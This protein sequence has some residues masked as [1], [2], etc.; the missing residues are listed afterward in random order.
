VRQTAAANVEQLAVDT[1]G[2]TDVG[3]AI[4]TLLGVDLCPRLSHLR[5]RRLHSPREVSVPHV[6]ER[7][8]DRDVS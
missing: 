4:S 5:D 1:H 7:V 6:L 8:V 2:Y 3:M